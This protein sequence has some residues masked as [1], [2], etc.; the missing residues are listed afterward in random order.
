MVSNAPQT[1]SS[2]YCG[3]RSISIGHTCDNDQLQGQKLENAIGEARVLLTARDA[4]LLDPATVA[5][6]DQAVVLLEKARPGVES[7]LASKVRD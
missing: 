2:R 5:L 7:A 3:S 1:A 6:I 4:D